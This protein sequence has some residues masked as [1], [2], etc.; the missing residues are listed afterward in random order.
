M[1]NLL[2]SKLKKNKK[3]CLLT[4]LVFFIQ[5]ICLNLLIYLSWGFVNNFYLYS[6]GYDNANYY[7]FGSGVNTKILN[8]L[9]PNDYSFSYDITVSTNENSLIYSAYTDESSFLNNYGIVLSDRVFTHI[10][11]KLSSSD[12]KNYSKY[13]LC[14][15]S[16]KGDN[17]SFFKNDVEYQLLDTVEV[18]FSK[19]IKSK[20][21]QEGFDNIEVVLFID[22]TIDILNDSRVCGNT[23]MIVNSNKYLVTYGEFSKGS[24]LNSSYTVTY[25]ALQVVIY[26]GLLLPF[27]F[28]I[29]AFGIIISTIQKDSIK[30][31][32]IFRMFGLK[33]R[34][35]NHF[36]LLERI[37]EMST[38]FVIS[39]LIFLVPLMFLMNEFKYL[40]VFIYLA[41]FI[42]SLIILEI[43]TR[44]ECNKSFNNNEIYKGG[45]L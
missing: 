18:S 11:S 25:S 24:D 10:K 33:K 22:K 17:S 13:C 39:S 31:I 44:K 15:S 2:F 19:N 38:A 26:I 14:S 35:A 12:V 34:N 42:Y 29:I 8:E 21:K 45:I 23:S 20:F 6:F 3:R 32:S 1:S 37:I 30:E 40:I 41:E 43:K 27:V 7:D 36:I 5:F 28:A 9:N 4:S 16:L